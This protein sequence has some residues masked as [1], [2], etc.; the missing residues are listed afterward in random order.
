MNFTNKLILSFAGIYLIWGST[1]LGVKFAV[2]G[3]PPLLMGGI[4]FMA[5]GLLFML[6]AWFRNEGRPKLKDWKNGLIVGF[7]MNF[8]G[9][10]LTFM[11][12]AHIPS[13][14]VALICAT[15][16][17]WVTF[18]DRVFVSRQKLSLFTYSGLLIGFTGVVSLLKPDTATGF[19]YLY[20]LPVLFSSMC[21]A[22]GSILPKKLEMSSSTFSNLGIQLFSGS[23]F[24]IITS[25]FMGEFNT[26]HIENVSLKSLIALV[27]LIIFGGI[28]VFTCYNW[29]LNNYDAAKVSTYG[30]VNPLLAVMMGNFFGNEPLTLKVLISASVILLGVIIIVLSKASVKVKVN[31]NLNR[32]IKQLS[33]E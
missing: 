23:I 32:E 8:C 5:A 29:L 33:Y 22:L 18:F 24:F 7:V 9:Q 16:P 1:Y 27:Y 17:L 31:V 20:A 28:I 4:R 14:I 25:Y 19:N 21:W 2:E 3:F 15:V 11:A 12:A 6:F 26:F 13:A 10:A 30:F